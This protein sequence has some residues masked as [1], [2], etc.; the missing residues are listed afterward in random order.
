MDIPLPILTIGRRFDTMNELRIACKHFAVSENFEFKVQ[1]S[2]TKR[3]RIHCISSEGCPW[4]LHASLIT[5]DGDNSKI[6]EIKTFV[7]EHTCNGVRGARHRQAGATLISSSIQGRLQEQ[8]TYRAVY[9]KRDARREQGVHISYSTAW[10]AKEQALEVINGSHV[11]A[12]AQLPQYCVDLTQA[13]PGSII[14]L[15]RTSENRFQRIFLCYAASA[16]G[17]GDCRPV[18]GLDGAHLK[19]KY[20]GILLSA[21]TVD[22]NGALF[23]LAH[24]V[25]DAEND[26]NWHWFA[27]LLYSVIQIHASAYLH[28]GFL[29]FVSD[30]QKGLLEAIELVFPSSPHGYC[31]RHLYEN[32]HKQFKHPALRTFLYQAARAIT[33]EEYNK[34]IDQMHDINSD[35]VDWLL[36]HAPREHWCEYYF[37]GQR[38]GHITSNIAESLNAWLAEAREKPIIAMLEQIRHQLMGWFVTRRQ[39]DK[40]TEGILVSSAAKGIKTTLTTRARRYRVLEA[41]GLIYEVFSTE[42]MRTYVVR[43]DNE[44]CTCYEWQTSGIPCGHALAV[45]LERNDDPQTYAKAFFRLDAFRGTYENPIF[46]PNVNAATTATGDESNID[47]TDVLLPPITRR[48]PGRPKKLRIRGA[49][50]GGREKR[51]FRCGSCGNTGHSKK[52]CR[53]PV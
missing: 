41:T 51:T 15:E 38:Y 25:V 19:G 43:L 11:E 53:Q 28:P 23:P 49:S 7:P 3:Y 16:I 50:E 34:A 29:S 26:D 4:L 12:Y 21:T 30:R 1:K 46:P 27:N 24:A 13:N 8:P 20:L 52:T 48:P 36:V 2:D 37:P 17:F 32:L 31:L 5:S 39:M 22:A 9:V 14:S 6:V 42:T 40:D 10:R 47:D 18:L 33:E 35:S 45:S 44:T